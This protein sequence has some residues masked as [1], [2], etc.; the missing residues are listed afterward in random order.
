FPRGE[1]ALFLPQKPYIPIATLRA[2]VAYPDAPETYS[3]D[4]ITAALVDVGLEHLAGRLDEEQHWSQQLSGGEQQRLAFARALLVK[5]GWLFM[6][7]ASSALDE[8]SE[9]KLYGMLVER[10]PDTALVSI[11]HRSTIAR[12]H[13][14][15]LDF[16]GDGAH[17]TLTPLPGIAA[18]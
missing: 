9:A 4:A 5:P 6:D 7:E 17:A 13:D 1:R 11:A 18:A 12:F 8:T 14:R 15:R 3:E 10:L 16:A 2:A